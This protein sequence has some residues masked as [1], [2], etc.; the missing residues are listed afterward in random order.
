MKDTRSQPGTASLWQPSAGNTGLVLVGI[1][2]LFGGSFMLADAWG[3]C[4]ASGLIVFLFG[5][6]CDLRD[7]IWRA[8]PPPPEAT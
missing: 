1:A 8:L 2:L 4:V 6:A 5:L 7:N 3:V